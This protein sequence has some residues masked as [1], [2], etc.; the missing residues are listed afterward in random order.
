MDGLAVIVSAEQAQ[1]LR[2]SSRSR[3]GSG[4]G[5]GTPAQRQQGDKAIDRLNDRVPVSWARSGE[6][7]LFFNGCESLLTPPSLGSRL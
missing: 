5:I 3:G 7:T 4:H 2:P 1:R 6:G